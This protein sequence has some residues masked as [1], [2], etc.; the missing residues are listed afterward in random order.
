MGI[1]K[2]ADGVIFAEKGLE[3]AFDSLAENSPLK[4]SIKKAIKDIRQNVFCG[5]QIQKDKIPKEYIQKYKINNLWWYPLSD[6][7]RLVYSVVTPSN[8]E[9]LGVIIEYFDHKSYERRFGY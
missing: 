8:I 1:N 7:L 4:K 6:A 9:I 3:L 5:N 2:P